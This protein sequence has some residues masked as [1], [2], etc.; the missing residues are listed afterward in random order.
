MSTAVPVEGEKPHG[1]RPPKR[2]RTRV[3]LLKAAKEI[4]EE[5]GF[6]ET[7]ISDIAERAGV[8][9]GLLY[10]YFESKQEIFRELAAAVDEEL[11]QPMNLIVDR[12]SGAT[13]S[14]RLRAAIRLHFESYRD[15]ARMMGV[16]EQASRYDEQ[17]HAAR[18]KLHKRESDRVAHAIGQL[19]RRGL[20]DPR[21]DPPIAA[22]ALGSMTWRFA[23][24]WL[25]QGALE[26]DFDIAVEQLTMLFMNAL[27]LTDE[28]RTT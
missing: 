8:S 17:V 12:S 28:N 16:I 5:K 23:E 21:L 1:P 7:R 10:H 2:A 22:E 27:Q 9:H 6:L 13:P 3:R 25:V 26:G 19:Q 14:E 18:A 24:R 4:F 15:E 20:A 11:I